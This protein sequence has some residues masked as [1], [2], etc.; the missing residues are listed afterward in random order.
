MQLFK[1]YHN[2]K[3]LTGLYLLFSFLLLA[4]NTF[5][6]ELQVNFPPQATVEN[7]KIHLADIAEITGSDIEK[8]ALNQLTIAIAPKPGE[9][10]NLQATEI[11][12]YIQQ[13]TD[14]INI[15]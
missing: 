5:A 1:R 15:H 6:A 12:F 7:E 10:T 13:T 3:Q 2:L 4:G 8:D 11:I 14:I 9:S